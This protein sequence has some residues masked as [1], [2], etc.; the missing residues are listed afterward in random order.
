MSTMFVLLLNAV[1]LHNIV[2]ERDG[3][4][5]FHLQRTFIYL[6]RFLCEFYLH[7]CHF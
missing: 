4:V 3:E 6:R 5:P 2:T 1:Q 7:W